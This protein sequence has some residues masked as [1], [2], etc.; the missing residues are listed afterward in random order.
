[1]N[2]TCCVTAYGVGLL[3]TFLALALMGTAQPALLYIVPLTLGTAVIVGW[4]RG[5]LRQMWTGQ[6]VSTECCIVHNTDVY[7]YS[8]GYWPRM[9]I[10][11][12]WHSLS[13]SK[14]GGLDPFGELDLFLAAAKDCAIVGERI[15]KIGQYLAKSIVSPFFDS[16]C[17]LASASGYYLRRLVLALW[18]IV[19][20]SLVLL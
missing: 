5:E 16:R 1:M 11:I 17:V 13:A 4:L 3:V 7:K 20:S 18:F 15:V 2:L 6:P 14:D 12:L 8:S 19:L 9:L 10:N